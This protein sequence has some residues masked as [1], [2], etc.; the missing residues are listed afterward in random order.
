[1]IEHILA[2]T[3]PA[4]YSVL[5][6]EMV[7]NE[8]TALLIAI[9]AQES[10]F[11]HRRQVNGPARGFWQFEIGGVRGVL[12][13]D[14]SRP[15]IVTALQALRYPPVQ[16]PAVIHLAL[17][18]NDVLAA[19]FARCLLWTLPVR[20]PGP[21]DAELGWDQYVEAWRPGRPR[22]ETWFSY[23]VTAWGAVM[24]NNSSSQELKA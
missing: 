2:Y 13:H 6:P 12:R 19:C 17:E 11:Q 15:A 20:L 7:S 18:H 9:G 21:N 8:A 3:L 10:R 22:H 16:D 24:N 14:Q 1:M 4:A 23:Y 5:P